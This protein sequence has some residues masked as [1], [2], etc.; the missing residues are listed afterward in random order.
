[1]SKYVYTQRKKQFD[2]DGLET[3]EFVKSY[4]NHLLVLEDKTPKTVLSYFVTIQALLKWVYLGMPTSKTDMPEDAEITELPFSTAEL[5][6]EQLL[7]YLAYCKTE[8]KNGSAAILNKIAAIKSF[9]KYYSEYNIKIFENPAKKIKRPSAAEKKPKYL[10]DN[11]LQNLKT[12]AFYGQMPARNKCMVTLL[13]S[14]GLRIGELVNINIDDINDDI[15]TVR[16]DKKREITLNISTLDTIDA[17]LKERSECYCLDDNALF[18][19]DQKGKRVTERAVQKIL[20]K[21]FKRAGL[22]AKDYSAKSL[23]HTAAINMLKSSTSDSQELSKF[24][25]NSAVKTIDRYTEALG[26]AHA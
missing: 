7:N 12:V 1:M 15:L 20:N 17:W 8:L 25:G 23:R 21:I 13:I 16:G 10:T 14:C 5:T 9:Y 22:E 3:P 26:L 4:L 2:V 11:E 24:M 18:I 6:E 19:S